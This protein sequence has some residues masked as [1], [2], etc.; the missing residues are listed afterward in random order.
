MGGMWVVGS[1]RFLV[2]PLP[3]AVTGGAG[4]LGVSINLLW[5]CVGGA[6]VMFM[7]GGFALVETGFTRRKNAAHTM[8]MNVAIF[9]TAFCSLLRHR[10]RA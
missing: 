6:L 7:Q 4:G 10:V 1:V 8:G 2:E 9:G 5:I 3:P